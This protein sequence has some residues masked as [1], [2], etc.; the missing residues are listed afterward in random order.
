MQ[1]N[2][3][4]IALTF[5]F[6]AALLLSA[7]GPSKKDKEEQDQTVQQENAID[8]PTV[9]LVPVKS[10]KLTSNITVPGELTPY[11]QVNLYAK[12]NSYVKSL[13]VDIG[14]QVHKGE[15]LA[16]LE[17]PEINSQLEAAKSRI[18][19]NKAVFFASKAT[20]DRLYSTSKTPGTVSQN[21]LE[22]ASAKMQSDSAN[23]EAAKSE[24]REVAANLAYLEIRAP[25]DGVITLRNIN[26]GTYVG[27]GSG[28]NLP[29]FVLED[30]KR[31]RLVISVPENFTGGL[32]DKSEVTFTVKELPNQKFTA[33]VKRLAGAL[34]ETLRS[35]RLEMDV[36][37]DNN[38]LLP[39]MYADVNVP[40]PAKDSALVVPKSSVVTSTEKVFV[41]TVA[42][43]HAKWVNVQKGLETKDMMEVYGDL[44]AG[45]VVVK[46][47]TDEI[48][49]GSPVKQ[50]KPAA[51]ADNSGTVKKDSTS[52]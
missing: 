41:I 18:Q 50:G 34:D 37:N 31:L 25:F 36:Y 46:L 39:N 17:A 19:Q 35:E 43:N 14:S 7:C 8:T 10:G 23:V 29:L 4:N 52:K 6:S 48:R 42:D 45:D 2:R 38:K 47:G 32:S 40:L 49:D 9:Q 11:Q 27:P 12:I 24:Y 22:Q 15:L 26:P 44:K 5:L 33:Q 16:T 30:H 3:S 20:Y 1:K 51:V 13:L 21:D 28:T